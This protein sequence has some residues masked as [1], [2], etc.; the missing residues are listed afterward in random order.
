MPGDIR[1][2]FISHIHEDDD[3]LT[4]LKGL[5][6]RKGLTCRDA[7]ITKGKFN[8]AQNEDYIKYQ[9]LAPRINWCSV[10]VVYISAD[11]ASSDW[12]NWEISYAHKQ[13]KRIVGV[14][15]RGSKDSEMPEVLERYGDALVGWNGESIIDAIT[16]DSSDWRQ[17]D[18]LRNDYRPIKRFSCG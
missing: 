9:I 8:A 16:G 13:G 17:K 10:L 5:V 15:E 14:W 18:G 6:S 4:D 11:T 7:S 1:N 3:G 2:V 12:V